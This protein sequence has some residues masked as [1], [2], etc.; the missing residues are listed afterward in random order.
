MNVHRLAWQSMIPLNA[1]NA[2]HRWVMHIGVYPVIIT[3]VLHDY[4]AC[5]AYHVSIAI[6]HHLDMTQEWH[7][8][9]PECAI[10]VSIDTNYY[11]LPSACFSNS[12]VYDFAIDWNHRR[13]YPHRPIPPMPWRIDVV[14][15]IVEN[16]YR[17]N[18]IPRMVSVV[19]VWT[20]GV[21]RG[22]IVR[23]ILSFETMWWW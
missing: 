19:S 10:T 15:M 14:R 4:W 13:M 18:L 23:M 12:Y 17:L 2:Y 5:V 6:H 21:E 9:R 1:W 7:W 20:D 8:A 22:R 11:S 16:L 3:F